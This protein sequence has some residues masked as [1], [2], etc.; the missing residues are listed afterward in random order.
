MMRKVRR[1]LAATLATVAAAT[2][3]AALLAPGGASAAPAATTSY[4]NP[5]SQGF[6]DTFADPS[7]IRG[8]D[9]FWYAYGTSDPLREGEG[10]PHRIPIARSA[11]LVHWS[12]V[13]DAFTDATVP[14]WAEADAR[15][16]GSRHPLRRRPVPPLLRRHPD[17]GHRRAGRQRDRHGHRP[18]P[19]RT[20]DGQRCPGRRPAARRP[21]RGRQLPV[22]LRPDGRHRH[23]RQ[24]VAVLRL[25]LRRPVHHQADRRRH[26]GGRHARP[27]GHRQQVR[28]LVRRPPR[29]LLVPLRLDRQLL[30]RAHHRVQRPGRALA[31]PP[32]PLRRP[33]GRAADRLPRRRHPGADAERQPLGRRRAQ[34]GRHRPG[35]PGLDRLPRDRPGRP[36]PRRHGR[37]QRAADAAGPPRLGRRLAHRARRPGAQRGRRAGPGDRGPGR[38]GVLRG[39]LPGGRARPARGRPPPTPVRRLPPFRRRRHAC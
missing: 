16:L 30:C 11:D 28:G 19:D 23:R 32:G 34:R 4:R 14:R 3:G 29:R 21:G 9:G 17:H 13:A 31:Q 35:R 27:G 36:L 25:L 7:L 38:H 6:A 33:A 15:H 39:R 1:P 2:L 20:V 37:H 12:H 18:H 26:D 8:K 10:R 5:V 22:D 24:P